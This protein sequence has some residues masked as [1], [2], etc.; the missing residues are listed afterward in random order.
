MLEV[1]DSLIKKRRVLGLLYSGEDQARIGCGILR[2]ER[3]HG[4]KVT[5]ISDDR[6]EF[7][8]LFELRNFFQ[9][10]GAH[11]SMNRTLFAAA[12]QL[13][14]SVW[15]HYFVQRYRI[16]PKRLQSN[17]VNPLQRLLAR[18]R[19]PIARFKFR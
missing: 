5:R 1:C 2:F 19:D 4:L 18:P 13:L 9:C 16:A 11:I 17:L 12:V 14:F 15:W 10:S 7:F 6:G 8:E 3:P